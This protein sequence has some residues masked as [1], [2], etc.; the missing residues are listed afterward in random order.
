VRRWRAAT[1]LGPWEA[2]LG[3]AEPGGRAP[4]A[5]RLRLAPARAGVLRTG[6]AYADAFVDPEGLDIGLGAI[7]AGGL[8]ARFVQFAGVSPGAL[9]VE[10]G[11]GTG[12][13]TFEGGLAD[14]A[15]PGGEV[16]ATDPAGPLLRVL[17]GKRDRLSTAFTA[18]VRTAWA[19]AEALPLADAQADVVCG[20]RFLQYCAPAAAVAEMARVARPGGSVAV[21]AALDPVLAPAWRAV[22][23]PLLRAATRAGQPRPHGLLHRPGDVPAAFAA[24]GLEQVQAQGQAHEAELPDAVTGLRLISQLSAL[25]ALVTGLPAELQQPLL[26]RAYRDLRT[27]LAAAAPEARRLVLRYELVRG[28]VP[29]PSRPQP[30]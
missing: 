6:A 15:G 2:G 11:A 19:P 23:A 28:R 22:L 10:V 26:D 25:E 8:L 7:S 3:P 4:G 30:H 1:S 12:L 20:S 5:S 29:A 27:M 17:R 14:A 21:L 16:L 24:C 13:L 9:V 18:P